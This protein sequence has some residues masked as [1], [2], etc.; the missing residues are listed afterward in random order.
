MDAINKKDRQWAFAKFITVYLLLALISWF[1]WYTNRKAEDKDKETCEKCKHEVKDQIVEL[2]QLL[3]LIKFIDSSLQ[4]KANVISTDDEQEAATLNI[5]IF[6]YNENISKLSRTDE[7]YTS[8]VLIENTKKIAELRQLIFQ[9]NSNI[10]A[11]LNIVDQKRPKLINTSIPV[12]SN[13]TD[14]EKVAIQTKFENCEKAIRFKDDKLKEILDKLKE[15]KS[16]IDEDDI[17]NRTKNKFVKLN[18]YLRETVTG[19]E[20]KA[21]TAKDKQ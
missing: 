9:L 14:P 5:K 7:K 20:Q 18:S 11:H 13:T 8:E 10:N 21:T 3:L 1:L 6:Y 16:K 4:S 17:L 12:Q 15:M 19:I 2:D